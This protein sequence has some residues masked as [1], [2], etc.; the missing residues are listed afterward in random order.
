MAVKGIPLV[1]GVA[2]THADIV[3]NALGVPIVE[4][5]EISYSDMQDITLNY[6][7]GNHPTSRGFGN[8]NPTA[9]ITVAKKEVDRLRAAAPQGK[10]QN[11]PDFPIRINYLPE[12]GEFTS[13]KLKRCRFKGQDVSSSQNNSNI[14]VTLEL[15]VAEI[16]YG[17]N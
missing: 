1:N 5:T 16:E 10:I 15:S 6:G 8:I 3:V 7:T 11:I 14:Y 17:A 12:S 4:I 13:D 9:S 2:Y